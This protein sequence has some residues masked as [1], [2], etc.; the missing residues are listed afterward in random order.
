MM[1]YQNMEKKEQTINFETVWKIK[2]FKIKA[3]KHCK[4]FK[5]NIMY[6]PLLQFN[7]GIIN[8]IKKLIITKNFN[9]RNVI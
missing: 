2:K 9:I 6:L 7:N 5:N 8:N 1:F 4:Y 3:P